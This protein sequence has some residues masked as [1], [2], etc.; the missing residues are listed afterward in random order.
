MRHMLNYPPLIK[1][2]N[3]DELERRYNR[4]FNSHLLMLLPLGVFA[5]L[6]YQEFGRL[7]PLAVTFTCVCYLGVMF[8]LHSL[9]LRESKASMRREGLITDD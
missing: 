4:V 3:D 7:P 1:K 6:T 8:V 5:L 9:A 2:F